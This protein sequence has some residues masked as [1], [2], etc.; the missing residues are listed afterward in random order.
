MHAPITLTIRRRNRAW[1]NRLLHEAHGPKCHK[2]EHRQRRIPYHCALS[3]RTLRSPK[4]VT[5]NPEVEHRR[6]IGGISRLAKWQW[7]TIAAAVGGSLRG[8][9]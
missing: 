3:I 8:E 2:A 4:A 7:K 5:A 6:H 1:R 9:S